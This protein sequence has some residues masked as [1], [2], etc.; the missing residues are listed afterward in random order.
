MSLSSPYLHRRGGPTIGGSQTTFIIVVAVAGTV[1]TFFSLMLWRAI[2]HRRARQESAPLPP[3]QA[4]AHHRELQLSRFEE[5]KFAASSPALLYPSDSALASS[6]SASLIPAAASYGQGSGA[7]TTES[8]TDELAP[9][10]PNFHGG[11][12]PQSSGSDSSFSHSQGHSPADSPSHRNSPL[13]SPSVTSN[14][15]SQSTHDLRKA[16]RASRMSYSSASPS[17]MSAR[18]R[19]SGAPHARHSQV[20]IVLPAPLAPGL[21][22]HMVIGAEDAWGRRINTPD[23]VSTPAAPLSDPW[24]GVV[25][26]VRPTSSISFAEQ[27]GPGLASK[28]SSKRLSSRTQSMSPLS[29]TPSPVTPGQPPVPRL[30][31]EY[32]AQN[33]GPRVNTPP[34]S[35]ALPTGARPPGPGPPR[36]Q[37]MGPPSGPPSRNSSRV[38]LAGRAA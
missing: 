5:A 27:P 10:T 32:S 3:P 4:L 11:S 19:S 25:A 7:A 26:G 18:S 35:Y 31:M 20:Q 30:P 13:P 2:R 1:A 28:R 12:R 37:S 22:D 38:D 34:S 21:H 17:R 14:S 23:A 6:S 29:R 9:P 24:T 33:G 15:H 8:A 16:H 36:S